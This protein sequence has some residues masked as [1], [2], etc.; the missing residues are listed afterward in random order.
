MCTVYSLL[1]LSV[2]SSSEEL[3]L[4][5]KLYMT[6]YVCGGEEVVLAL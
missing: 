3:W 2:F 5:L 4:P 6:G 1:K